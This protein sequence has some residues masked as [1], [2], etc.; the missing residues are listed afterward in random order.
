MTFKEKY[1]S[2]DQTKLP[3]TAK[4]YMVDFKKD[5]NNFTNK[6]AMAKMMPALDKFIA[7]LKDSGYGEAIK[8][9]AK[10][11]T[12]KKAE[13]PT[14]MAKEIVEDA[15]EQ[16]KTKTGKP[17][18]GKISKGDFMK[19]AKEIRKE[20]ESW[21]DAMKRAGEIIRKQ[22]EGVK[23]K[24]VRQYEKLKKFIAKHPEVYR[25][26]IPVRGG[27][28]R[29]TTLEV[30][31]PR[32]ALPRG[33]RVSKKGW[34]NQYGK[35]DGGKTYYEY[36]SNRFD[37]N[38]KRYPFL[39]DGG[40]INNYEVINYGG[41][42]Y[43]GGVVYAV[44]KNGEIISEDI[45]YG[46]HP[47]VF[48]GKE[49]DGL[50]DLSK[51][52][53]AKLIQMSEYADGGDIE[54]RIKVGT[55]DEAQLRSQEDKKAVEKAQKETGLKYVDTKIIKKGGKMFMEVYLIPTEEYLKSSKFAKGGDIE[56]AFTVYIY[57]GG[58]R[59]D[60]V[61]YA[62]TIEQARILA[63]MGEHSEII[64]NS[65]NEMLEFAKGGKIES[66]AAHI[67][68]RMNNGIY[69][70]YHGDYVSLKN[71]ATPLFQRD[72]VKDG[73]WNTIWNNIRDAKVV[74]GEGKESGSAHLY[75]KMVNGNYKVY[76]GDDVILDDDAHLLY[77]KHNVE[78]GTWGKILEDL[79]GSKYAKGGDIPYIV[80]TSKNGNTRQ[81]YKTYNSMKAA[82]TA[83][84]KLFNSGEYENVGTKSKTAYEK[85]GFY[86]DG[87]ETE[88]VIYLESVGTY[89]RPSDLM[90]SPSSAFDDDTFRIDEIE[91]DE[92]FD[93]LSKKDYDII[94]KYYDISDREF[95]R[96][97][98]K[99]G[100]I[101][102][103]YYEQPN[104]GKAKYTVN[105]HDGVKTHKDGS[106][107]Y[108]MRIFKNKTDLNNF[109]AKLKKEGYE[110]ERY[111]K[112][113][114]TDALY[115]HLLR[116]YETEGYPKMGISFK[117]FIESKK[118]TAME[119]GD[120]EMYRK[121][122][123]VLDAYEGDFYAKGGE[124]YTS[125]GMVKLKKGD[126]VRTRDGNIETVSRI[127]SNGNVETI[128][129]DYSHEPYTLT[130][131]SEHGGEL[132]GAG[133]FAKGG[134]ISSKSIYIPNR[135]INSVHAKYKDKKI[136]L[137]GSDIYDGLYVKKTAVKSNSKTG[138]GKSTNYK[139]YGDD[140]SKLIAFDI[141]DLDPFE[142]MQY[143]N[144]SKN[145]SKAESLQIL[146]NNVE[147]DYS[148][149]SPKLAKIAEEQYPSSE[150]DK[151]YS[152]YAK[153]GSISK[154]T[155]YVPNRDV[156]ELMVVLKGEL[157]KLKGKD[158]LDG[159]YVKNKR[160]PS[161]STESPKEI[162]A[163]LK[164]AAKDSDY[165][166][167]IGFDES[168]IKSLLES[169]FS[170]QDV[171]NIYIG[172]TP[173]LVNAD[174]EFGK[175]TSGL[176]TRSG[177][178]QKNFIAEI[179]KNAKNGYFE[180]GLKY[181]NDFNWKPI[182]EKYDISREPKIIETKDVVRKNKFEIYLGK[183]VAIGHQYSYKYNEDKKWSKEDEY[184]ILDSKNPSFEKGYWGI[185]T[186]N[187]EDMY[188]IVD[189]LLKQS[190]GYLKD[191]ELFLNRLGGIG[192][193][194]VENEKFA[195]GGEVGV[196]KINDFF[197]VPEFSREKAKLHPYYVTNREGVTKYRAKSKSDAQSWIEEQ[198]DE[199]KFAKGGAV[200]D[201]ELKAALKT[202][203]G[204]SIFSQEF[205][206][207]YDF[208]KENY[209]TR[210]YDN[211][212][213][214]A[215]S[216]KAELEEQGYMVKMKK[217]GFSDLARSESYFV[218][219]IK[220]KSHFAKGG[221]VGFKALSDKVAKYYSNKS[222]PSKYQSLYGKKYDK[223]EAKEVGDKV[224]AKVYR[225]QLA[226]KK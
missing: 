150:F 64:D 36:R 23:T 195:K 85:N 2:I 164:K 217:V 94:S 79:K 86:A 129:N 99:G 189:T 144:F 146:I 127:N 27:G 166:A 223:S 49:Y 226:K 72:N 160:K 18:V 148:Q 211:A 71:G 77:E 74:K 8:G 90:T 220:R 95:G 56:K 181:P 130:K 24:A 212:E 197:I 114:E 139:K 39:A 54:G 170:A 207:K 221:K 109:I 143:E 161:P 69:K 96:R 171:K 222:V 202:V 214:M 21:N 73:T 188:F 180:I 173:R 11:E 40:D 176:I 35:S 55:F 175:T 60:E 48:E 204:G 159:V 42:R 29:K 105:F 92:W 167:E 65:T 115:T 52:I 216:K 15:I 119:K 194:D 20:G 30:D 131:I 89:F 68:I 186:K 108:D 75:I 22:K 9:A 156:K 128:E 102:K 190:K 66:G 183:G 57:Y 4:A 19:I 199:S 145:M 103:V 13:T 32:I 141:D 25:E 107:F 62:D 142:S 41:D 126:K 158:I 198:Y 152:E 225:Q 193:E 177:D 123:D 6:E 31:A 38:R 44:K 51:S 63:Q 224:A 122:F 133:R 1:N 118:E 84:Q 61:Q 172:Y 78:E 213:Q 147:G 26:D 58:S 91:N 34:K 206:D 76:H 140:N 138:G 93:S 134:G 70:V 7:A 218:T 106:P 110:Y 117:T 81:L 53:G 149:L 113:G 33:K 208:V 179:V 203:E 101:G 12:K 209:S 192:V 184:G 100:N 191:C 168:D 196:I 43:D 97:Y 83:A 17:K 200:N 187:I 163:V 182:I 121:L 111:A 5:S 136:A 88:K 169:G 104:V 98:A 162:M 165:G 154:N 3:E 82:E 125:T 151:D 112:G 67:Y 116:E 124:V 205:F 135:D 50:V 153:G 185:V 137:D 210:K 174:T 59:P 178:S 10:K 46:D 157:T 201:E 28:F 80:W 45:I 120:Y 37:T 219:A 16:P 87:G 215:K 132:F 47:V 155:T 14:E